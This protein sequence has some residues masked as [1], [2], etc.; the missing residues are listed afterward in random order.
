[1][2]TGWLI[3]SCNKGDEVSPINT[4]LTDRGLWRLASL[5]TETLNGDTTVD[6]DT[7]NTSCR[8]NQTFTFNANGTCTY[9]Y[10]S[11]IDQITQG[12]WELSTISSPNDDALIDSVILRSGMVCKDTTKVGTSQPFNKARVINLGQNSLVLEVV[13]TDTLRKTPVVVLRRKITTYG[14][15]H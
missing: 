8:F 7:L 1:M 9:E 12:N 2:L 10:F 13:R 14:F 3:S 6:R 15:I 5:R 4:F 11:C